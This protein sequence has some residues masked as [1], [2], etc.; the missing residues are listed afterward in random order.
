MAQLYTVTGQ[1]RTSALDNSGHFIDVVEITF[2]TPSGDVGTLR[3]NANDYMNLDSVRGKLE[4]LAQQ[5][6]NIRNL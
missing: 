1:R 5:M 4:E 6:E 2:T 3:V